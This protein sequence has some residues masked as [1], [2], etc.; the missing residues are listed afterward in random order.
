M[1][2]SVAGKARIDAFVIFW[3]NINML[4]TTPDSSG[5][6]ESSEGEPLLNRLLQLRDRVDSMNAEL[7]GHEHE[8]SVHQKSLATRNTQVIEGQVPLCP[9]SRRI[10]NTTCNHCLFQGGK[11]K[12]AT[13]L[14][15]LDF[16]APEFIPA[17][18]GVGQANPFAAEVEYAAL[19]GVSFSKEDVGEFLTKSTH[20]LSNASEEM[21]RKD[22]DYSMYLYRRSDAFKDI[23]KQDTNPL[24]QIRACCSILRQM[25]NDRDAKA[26]SDTRK[27]MYNAEKIRSKQ[28][29]IV[30]VLDELKPIILAAI[31]VSIDK[32]KGSHK[33]VSS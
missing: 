2:L 12:I 19:L 33:D 9:L 29:F 11:Q 6:E 23:Q 21:R 1:W 20:A 5:T 27:Q 7:C 17:H 31:D 3:Y 24:G 26:G 10:H 4:T 28:K 25:I 15:S 14:P 22:P 13:L 32:E 30:F 8:V 16:K 18:Q